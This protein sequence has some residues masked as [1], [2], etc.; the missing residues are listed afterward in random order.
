MT[1]EGFKVEVPDGVLADL[2]DRLTRTRWA[3]D[4]GND[5]WRYGVNGDWLRSVVGYWLDQ[6]DWRAQEA[7]M[8]AFPQFRVR[9]DGMPVHFIHRRATG[10][11]TDA[12]HAQP[13]LAVDLLGLPEVIGP[14]T[15]PAAHGGDPADA[16]D[17]VVPSLPGFGFSTPLEGRDQ[18]V[19]DRRPVGAADAR[20][21]RVRA[22]R[23]PGGD[24]GAS[25]RHLGHRLRRPPAR[26]PSP[27]P[28]LRHRLRNRGARGPGP[29]EEE[30]FTDSAHQT[31]A[32]HV[33]VHIPDPQTWHARH[34]S[35]VGLPAWVLQRRRDWS[36][37]GGDRSGPSTRTPR[38][39]PWISCVA[40]DPPALRRATR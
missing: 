22:L 38:M 19:E 2:R 16:F 36:D 23:G 20:G 28:R 26:H 14:L 5:S 24:W 13:R 31:A 4:Y 1:P 11:E 34:D 30:W 3:A 25:S 21:A 37:S 9:L 6:Y 8:N 17:V 29:G 10:P 27:H 12:D 39:W 18:R 7:A 35:P 33:A 32:S 40:P 15:D